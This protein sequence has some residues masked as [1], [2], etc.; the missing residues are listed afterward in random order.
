MPLTKWGKWVFKI[1]AQG[2]RWYIGN[3]ALK[4]NLEQGVQ[5]KNSYAAE[6]PSPWRPQG[7][8]TFAH[9]NKLMIIVKG[10]NHTQDT[11]TNKKGKL[12]WKRFYHIIA[13]NLKCKDT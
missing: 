4:E 11:Q 13:Y 10:E 6:F 3:N 5:L 12:E 2:A 7:V 8:P 9:I 1:Y